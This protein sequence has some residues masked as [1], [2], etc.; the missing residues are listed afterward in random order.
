MNPQDTSIAF[1]ICLIVLGLL[2]LGGAS[3]QDDS[4]PPLKFLFALL[5]VC[6]GVLSVVFLL[7]LLSLSI[8]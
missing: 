5:L 3:T 1:I 7:R 2:L 6:S 4:F 8:F